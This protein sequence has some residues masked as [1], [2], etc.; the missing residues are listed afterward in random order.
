[1]SISA[2]NQFLE[3]F[4]HKSTCFLILLSADV[5]IRNFRKYA[6]K[7][8]LRAFRGGH[9]VRVDRQIIAVFREQVFIGRCR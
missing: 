1:M 9:R 3:P 6:L 8:L 2:G 4:K 7:Y 5:I